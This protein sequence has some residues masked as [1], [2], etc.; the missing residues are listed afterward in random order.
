[1]SRAS[2]FFLGAVAAA[3]FGLGLLGPGRSTGSTVANI[4]P[5]ICDASAAINIT[6]PTTTE[7][8]PA[9]AGRR[10][11]VCALLEE[12]DG[13]I[14][15]TWVHGTG[16]ACSIGQIPLTGPMRLTAGESHG[17]GAGVGLLFQAQWSSALCIVT[18]GAGS[19]RGFVSYTQY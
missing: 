3:A 17:V 11:R 1:M 19:V 12:S 10:I 8:I 2:C 13:A 5:V 15:V 7:I 6:T 4:L 16:A 14:S 9:S 18:S